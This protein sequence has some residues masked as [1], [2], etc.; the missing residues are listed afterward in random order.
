MAA[1]VVK[2][3]RPNLK[4]EQHTDRRTQEIDSEVLSKQMIF[5]IVK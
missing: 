1:V 5:H 3:V 4:D 2:M